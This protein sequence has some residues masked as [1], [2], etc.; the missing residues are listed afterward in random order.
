MEGSTNT[1]PP[2]SALSSPGR[3]PPAMTDV[4]AVAGVSH[5]AASRVLNGTGRVAPATREKVLAAIEQIGYR[6]NA[7]ARALARQRSE[8]IG[9]I[10][11][12]S[13]HH[14]PMSLLLAVELAARQ[15][16]YFTMVAPVEDEDPD[17]VRAVIDHF[18]G[19][20]VEGIVFIAPIRDVS[21]DLAKGSVPV[22]VV[23]VTS[24]EVGLPGV[25]PVCIDQ[26]QGSRGAMEHLFALG[27]EDIAHVPG[28]TTFFEARIREATWRTMMEE[29]G[30]QVREPQVRGWDAV[31]GYVEGMRLSEQG[32]PT[33]VFCAND[34]LALGLYKAFARGGI[35]V[36]EDV[37]V[38]GFDD[39]PNAAFYAPALTT[40]GQDFSELG[41]VVLSALV[42]AMEGGEPPVGGLMLP[43]TLVL[44][45]S[46][47]PVRA[48]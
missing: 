27:H 46:T 3:R 18:L 24:A 32:L 11:T 47:G 12:T 45:D 21:V 2:G 25:I 33:A 28:P 7:V 22:P 13:V 26:E 40:V 34:Q 23:A 19:L 5:Q 10:T 37:S 36:P 30:F 41:E 35:R 38:V 15:R 42:E 43:A 4:A 48:L 39:I 6:R 29:R 1:V 20:P 31:N 9:I 8:A 16:G 44:R 17:A 14:G